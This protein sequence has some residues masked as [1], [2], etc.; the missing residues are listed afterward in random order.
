MRMP[1]RVAAGAFVT[2]ALIAA[3]AA[4]SRITRASLKSLEQSADTSFEALVKED[5]LSILGSTRGVYLQ[6]YGVVFT[7]EV[8]LA[9]SA[10]PNPFRPALNKEGIAR[11]R[12]K[13]RVRIAFLKEN[14]RNML[15][16][17]ASSLDTVPL[18]E[19]VALA[20]TVPYFSWEDK[21]GMPQQ[22]LAVAPRKALLDAK[23]GNA[24]P[25]AAVMKVQEF[26]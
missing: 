9:A 1:L 25:L 2:L 5:P 14:M 18:N 23:A 7:T 21:D 26:F 8:E 11:L 13:K 24:A 10:A 15:V 6:G 22:I 17:F 4:P 3:V 19:N 20:V 16:S 12:E